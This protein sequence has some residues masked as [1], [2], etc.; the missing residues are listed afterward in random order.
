MT[1][2]PARPPLDLAEVFRDKRILFVGS[3]GF[4][5]KVA[6][7][8]LLRRYPSI[9]KVYVLVRPGAGSSAEDRFFR[10]VVSSPAFDPIREVWGA[11]FDAFLREKVV[12]LPG[13]AGRPLLNFSDEW[14]AA[15]TPLDAIINCAGLVTFDPTLESALRINTYGVKNV[16]EVARKTGAAVVHVSTCFVA[17]NRDGDIW[18]D[19]PL[20]GYYPRR[21]DDGLEEGPAGRE[22]FSVEG[23]IADCERL[24]EQV[25]ARAD[26]RAHQAMFR[27]RG[28]ERLR[29]EGRDADDERTLKIAVQRE[30]KTWMSAEL[31][32]LGMERA[33]QWGWPNTY[34]YTK[35]LGD[36]VCAEADAAEGDAHVRCCLVRPAIVE[37]A[38][39]YP[40]PGWNEGF[41]TTAPLTMLSLL[42]HRSFPV[43][44]GV[45]LDIIP[46]D[47]VA[48]GLIAATG[49]TI[50]GENELVY[51]LASG[52]VNPLW[53]ERALG[54]LGL[55]KRSYYQKREKGPKWL[56]RIKARLEPVRV[57]EQAWKT[58]SAPMWRDVANGLIAGIDRH[59]PRWGAPRVQA[60]AERAKEKLGEVAALS[61][62]TADAFDLFAPFIRERKYVFRCDHT[63]ALHARLSEADRQAVPWDPEALDWRKYWLDVHMPGL[64]EWVFPSLEEEFQ[65]RPKSVYTYKDLL[66]LFDATTKHHRQRT[67]MRMLPPLDDDGHFSGPPR[68]YTYGDLQALASRAAEVLR[69]RGVEPGDK[70]LLV[71]ENRPEWGMTY[72]AILKAGATVVPMDSASSVEEIANIVRSSRARAAVVSART[73]ERLEREHGVA[74]SAL[75]DALGCAR[76]DYSELLFDAPRPSTV[77]TRALAKAS[78]TAP[79]TAIVPRPKVDDLA[80]L[81]FTSGTTGR[82]KGVMLS[83]RNFSSLLA[84]LASV[85]DIDKHDGLLSV[86]PLH[87]TFEFTAGLL[88]PL[89]RGAQIAYLDE[90]SGETLS[91]AFDEGRV[92]GMVGVPALWQLLHRKITRQL[93]DRGT[94]VERSFDF[95]VEAHRR[96]RDRLPSGFGWLNL[97]RLLFF[98]VH[99]KLGGRL[100]LMISG[101]SALPIEVMKAFRGMGF[102]IYEGYGLTEAAPVLTVARPGNKLL[103]GSVGEPLPGIEVKIAEPDASG[104]G[105]VIASGPNVMVGYFEDAE[106]TAQAIRDG[107]LHTGDLGRIDDGRLVIVGR[108]KEMIL[109]SNGENVYPDELEELYRDSPW[110]KELSIVGL[111]V[112]GG[113]ETVA[114]LA[115]PDYEREDDGRD[116]AKERV[117]DRV[118]EH[119]RSVSGKLPQWKRVKVLHLSDHELPKTATRKVKRKAVV[120]EL[121]KLERLRQRG[122]SL[123]KAP[124]PQTAGGPGED[125]LPALLAEVTG[126][127]IERVQPS[128]P[129]A[130]LGFDSLMYTELGVALEGAGLVLPE[131]VDLTGIGTVDELA[132]MV[133]GLA[134][135]SGKARAESAATKRKDDKVGKS[136]LDEE[137]HVPAKVA[138]LGSAALDWAQKKTYERLFRT[139]V[140]GRAY[141]PHNTR[142]LVAANHASHLDMGLVKHALGDWGP[143]LVAL[144]AKDYFFDD[145][146]RRA[147]FEN[148]TNL[149]PMERHGS[150]RESLR[151]AADVVR[152]GHILLI[153]PEGTRSESGYMTDFKPS[154]GYLALANQID[155]LPMYLEGTHDAMP[156]GNLL[157]QKRELGAHIGPL[158]PWQ[159]LKAATAGLPRGEHYRAAA[160]VVEQAVRGLA[161]VG[162][163]DREMPEPVTEALVAPGEAAAG[164]ES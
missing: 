82:P 1:P 14:L 89:M 116:G 70:V 29:V 65:A 8:M 34:T 40:F 98:P 162:H 41:T 30:R 100:R 33:R 103:P 48:A 142:F 140:T 56:N 17:G 153:F 85:F 113:G 105:E 16:V 93:A 104:V 129:L 97:G 46:V 52:D 39:R 143:Q 6:L 146:L 99:A 118:R 47:H 74:T 66:E 108:K 7:S 12:P 161:P 127:P 133:A 21:D 90:L 27:E 26:D 23:E 76:L 106:A 54:L 156:K 50:A 91:A 120:E 83:H 96:F 81:I 152:R 92:T 78:S 123:R 9:G 138:E 119:F 150:L 107:W 137:I 5:G 87:H 144:A 84:K 32:A 63:R 101:G 122:E 163:P 110:V 25:R 75:G 37:S 77:R 159:K 86:L 15:M 125:F 2:T 67:A 11:G 121:Q 141:L 73:A 139:R 43:G 49:A 112:E 149:V 44:E 115:V 72:F 24:I 151:L 135:K 145:P 126:Q 71:S 68:R 64:E 10:K 94:A 102:G 45:I 4:V 134:R 164:G 38:L 157:P 53:V 36:Q 155:V 128:T 35:S 88:M 117:R 19:V 95:L 124:A 111:P 109:G 13:D 55:Y 28:A 132:R 3:T 148:F 136:F 59:M 79:L 31:T 130:E 18:E 62:K 160:R 69:A 154:I 58:R 51:Q 131:S 20:V 114:C 60:L 57:D 80:S 158:I 22:P 61:G 42:G 147:Y